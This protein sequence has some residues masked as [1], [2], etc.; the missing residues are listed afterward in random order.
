MSIGGAAGVRAPRSSPLLEPSIARTCIGDGV[1]P[2]PSPRRVRS[3]VQPHH[4]AG[5]TRQYVCV[6]RLGSP[7]GSWNLDSNAAGRRRE[8]RPEARPQPWG[9]AWRPDQGRL[10]VAVRSWPAQRAGRHLCRTRHRALVLRRSASGSYLGRKREQ[11]V[12]QI[13]SEWDGFSSRLVLRARRGETGLRR[14]KHRSGTSTE[15]GGSHPLGKV[16]VEASELALLWQIYSRRSKSL[17]KTVTA[18]FIVLLRSVSLHPCRRGLVVQTCVRSNE[19][20]RAYDAPARLGCPKAI[21]RS[22]TG[23]IGEGVSPM[24]RSRVPYPYT[25]RKGH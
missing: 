19:L 9:R 7:S 16:M 21:A 10:E 25:V 13:E 3:G 1:P 6:W 23:G 20:R 18:I 12:L 2:P 14:R 11:S 17:E 15:D 24:G 5:G 8:E 22:G 4:L